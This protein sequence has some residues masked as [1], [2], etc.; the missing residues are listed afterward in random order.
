MEVPYGEEVATRTDPESCV[1]GRKAVGEALAGGRAGRVL[2]REKHE[3]NRGAD[4]L[5][6]SGRPHPERRQRETLRDPARSETPSM[7][8]SISH[9]NREIPRPPAPGCGT[10]RIGNPMGESR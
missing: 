9:G 1:G 7:H 4:A 5:E 8:A 3:V 10:G 2:S 6:E